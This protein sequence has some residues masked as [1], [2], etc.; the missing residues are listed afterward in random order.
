MMRFY[1]AFVL[2]LGLLGSVWAQ[3]APEFPRTADQGGDD[4]V[5][6]LS[7]LTLDKGLFL[8]VAF[9][10]THFEYD[11][12]CLNWTAIGE[13]KDSPKV[14]VSHADPMSA[15]QVWFNGKAVNT[16]QLGNA[17]TNDNGTSGPVATSENPWVDGQN[18]IQLLVNCDQDGSAHPCEYQY[19]IKCNKPPDQG[20]E[21]VGDPQF[22]GLRGQS[23]QVHGVAGEV[24][25]IV[26]DKDVQYNSRFV[27]LT[28]G[29]CPV[30]EGKKL[31]GCFSHP[32]SYL[33]ELGL[34]TRAGDRIRIVAGS[35]ADGFA[36][37]E[38][39]GRMME[40]GESAELAMDLGSITRLNTHQTLIHI[41]SWEFMF[42]NSDMFINQRVRVDD[43][44]SLR[45]HGL[46]GQTWREVTYP[47][48]IKYIQ[49]SVDDYT[50]R[51]GDIFG[52]NFV[53]NSFN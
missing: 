3:E 48:A 32:G 16:R 12:S 51:D 13:G 10:P 8:T 14:T 33:G 5:C 29:D 23:F 2:L 18:L 27:F 20:G 25:N 35:A 1:L 34:K 22:V 49:G 38:L 47:N 11:C 15:T 46:L 36:A 21:V 43:A 28:S 50:I 24:Y 7:S 6:Q 4:Q 53:Y 45:S 37:V 26:S 17:L 52:D 39:N 44:R 31:Q 40:I 9:S 30:V 42:E 41:G 19:V